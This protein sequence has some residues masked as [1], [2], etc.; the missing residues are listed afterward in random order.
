M[1]E[2]TYRK[3]RHLLLPGLRQ[4]L[5]GIT[6]DPETHVRIINLAT[7]GVI[8]SVLPVLTGIPLPNP[9]GR[10]TVL[11]A[12]PAISTTTGKIPTTDLRIH[13][14]GLSRTRA[15]TLLPQAAILPRKEVRH[16]A[17]TGAPASRH[18]GTIR[19]SGLPITTRGRV[20]LPLLRQGLLLI[21]LRAAHPLCQRLV[22]VPPPYHRGLPR[23][24]GVQEQGA[25]EAAQ[26][27][28]E[29]KPGT[30]GKI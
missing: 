6:T 4:T 10:A 16:R 17:I 30:I 22:A 27:D 24:A 12:I 5:P 14:Q 13:I 29:D 20:H 3:R 9:T 28:Q 18:T 8:M 11:P 19:T 23:R 21:L 1:Q 26:Q 25:V 2:G 15:L 7:P